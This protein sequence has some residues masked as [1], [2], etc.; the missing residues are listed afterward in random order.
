MHLIIVTMLM[1]R[2]LRFGFSTQ[3]AV[4]QKL[5]KAPKLLSG[6]L[7]PY[8]L[9]GEAARIF[10]GYSLDE[11]YGSKVGFKHSPAVQAEMRK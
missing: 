11:L 10:D 7:E 4:S 1:R 9:D 3:R 6:E 8:R 5:P 2:A